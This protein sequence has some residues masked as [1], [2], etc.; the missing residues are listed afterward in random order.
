M[1]YPTTPD[2]HLT[3][4]TLFLRLRPDSPKREIAWREFYEQ[5]API[6]SGFSRKMGVRPDDV[7]DLIQ[8]VLL[9]FFSASPEFVY[10]PS[11]GRFRGY[12]KTCT[13]R[14]FQRRLGKQLR[15]S[16]RA[17]DDVDPAEFQVEATWNDVWESEK[18]Q[19]AMD[20]VRDRYLGRADKVK[21]FKAFELYVLLERDATAIATE[22]DMSVESV[23]QA[24]SRVSKAIRTAMD[25]IDDSAG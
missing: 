9:G 4:A 14:I 2:P 11:Q 19:R 23:H 3:R 13:W 24:K 8:D 22:L 15:V 5:Y 1:Q 7:G 20:I 25:A 21:T 17:L 6:I 16:G 18:L 12:L 10:E